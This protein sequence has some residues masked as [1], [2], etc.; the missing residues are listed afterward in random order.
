MWDCFLGR[1][2]LDFIAGSGGGYRLYLQSSCTINLGTR[3]RENYQS[4]ARKE[5]SKFSC[6]LGLGESYLDGITLST[7]SWELCSPSC[8]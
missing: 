2:P 5:K 1:V 7:K 8:C 6:G 3:D 4:T